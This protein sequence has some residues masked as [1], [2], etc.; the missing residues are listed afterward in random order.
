MGYFYDGLR[1]GLR[2]LIFVDILAIN[3]DYVN[4]IS[5]QQNHRCRYCMRVLDR[6]II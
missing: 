5:V 2:F 3:L 1:L 4:K 6:S